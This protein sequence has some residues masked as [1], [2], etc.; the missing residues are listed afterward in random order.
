MSAVS[1]L[2]FIQPANNNNNNNNYYYYYIIIIIIYVVIV[3]AVAAAA[4]MRCNDW[5]D[6]TTSQACQQV[7]PKTPHAL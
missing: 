7:T 4:A 1:H 2:E 3:V 5:P 6:V